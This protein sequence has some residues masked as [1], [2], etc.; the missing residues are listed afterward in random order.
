MK[1][2][3]TLQRDKANGFGGTQSRRNYW[4]VLLAV[5][6]MSLLIHILSVLKLDGHGRS[7]PRVATAPSSSVKIRVIEKPRRKAKPQPA[8]E[9]AKPILET[10]QT[11]TAAPNQP[12]YLGST[13]HQ[14][15]KETRL[16]NKLKREKAAEAGNKGRPDAGASKPQEKT[17]EAKPSPSDEARREQSQS[18]IQPQLGSLAVGSYRRK[19]RNAYE[20]LLPTGPADLA[21]QINAGFQDYVDERVAEGERIDIN[22]SEYRYIGYFT[23]MRKAIELVWNYPSDAA[24][25]GEQGEVGLEF[26]ITKDGHVSQVRLLRSSGYALLDQAIMQAIRLASP[27]SPLPGG[28]DKNRLVVTGSFR[29]VLNGL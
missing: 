6:L 8:S 15:L 3:P 10:P 21:G 12:S 27:F 1:S 19:P 16:S 24:R 14:A 5:L 4:L 20:A 17:A 28:I 23:S 13:N 7:R 22:T 9:P 11:P 25:K 18:E 26:V 29:Y 2:P